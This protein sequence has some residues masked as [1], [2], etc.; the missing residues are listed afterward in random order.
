MSTEGRYFRHE[1]AMARLNK[2]EEEQKIQE[3]VDQI[4]SD[5]FVRFMNANAPSPL[6]S[7]EQSKHHHHFVQADY[8]PE[9]GVLEFVCSCG[10][11]MYYVSD[12]D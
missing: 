6:F 11:K 9:E 2:K 12:E 8:Q 3:F 1:K 5:F 4:N 7:L 10:V